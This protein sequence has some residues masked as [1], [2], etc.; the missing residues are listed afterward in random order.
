MDVTPVPLGSA[1]WRV[2]TTED[3][4]ARLSRTAPALETRI[5]LSASG[6][7]VICRRRSSGTVIPILPGSSTPLR[8][9]FSATALTVRSMGALP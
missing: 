8:I 2:A 3:V 1:T 9:E 4:G 7:P 6:W 5:A